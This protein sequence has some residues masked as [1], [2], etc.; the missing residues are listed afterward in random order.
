MKLVDAYAV[1]TCAVRREM[2][3]DTGPSMV[4]GFLQ[5][6]SDQQLLLEMEDALA[7]ILASEILYVLG[8]APADEDQIRKILG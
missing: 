1:H 6:G 5:N 2:H 4:I 7:W 3:E 8:I